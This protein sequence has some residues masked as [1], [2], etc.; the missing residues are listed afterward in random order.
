MS[1]TPC[2][3]CG[4][5]STSNFFS[6]SDT[7]SP[8]GGVE[9]GETWPGESLHGCILLGVDDC[10]L[11]GAAEPPVLVVNTRGVVRVT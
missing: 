10:A 1:M 11:F 3:L 6:R 8:L 5:L 7:V 2:S 4:L 9:V